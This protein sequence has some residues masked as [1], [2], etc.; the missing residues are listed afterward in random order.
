MKT[1]SSFS[2]KNAFCISSIIGTRGS[3][4]YAPQNSQKYQ[5]V[6]MIISLYFFIG[7]WLFK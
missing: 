7:Y 4:I 1:G 2:L 3:G 6:L 5:V